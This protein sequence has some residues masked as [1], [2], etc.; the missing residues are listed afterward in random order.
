MQFVGK[1]VYPFIF[2]PNVS[3]TE[4]FI[5][6]CFINRLSMTELNEYDLYCFLFNESS[7]EYQ[8]DVVGSKLEHF[9]MLIV[10][11]LSLHST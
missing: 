5:K 1:I 10:S 9:H 7:G 2:A 11:L 6:P 4:P 8:V 3:V